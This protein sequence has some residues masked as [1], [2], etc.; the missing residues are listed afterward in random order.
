MNLPLRKLLTGIV[1]DATANPLANDA[2]NWTGCSPGKGNLIGTYRDISACALSDYL[3][4]PATV[5]D[6]R[7]LTE[8]DTRTI[9][10]SWWDKM[11]M[12]EVPDQDVANIV[13]HLRMH[14]GNVHI[15]QIALRQ[16]GENVDIDGQFGPQ[17]LEAL[18]RQ[19]RRNAG[20]TYTAIR[21]LLKANYQ[22]SDPSVRAGFMRFL[23][24]DFPEKPGS[25]KRYWLKAAI[26]IIVIALLWYGY[27]HFKN[28]KLRWK[29]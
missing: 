4:R 7:N 14:F 22:R 1:N 11:R 15:A 9:I 16:L 21:N 6:L 23:T 20:K 2:G 17:T 27:K 5:Q 28:Y 26:I 13:F 8:A 25:A 18:K 29:A 10:R 24:D 19:T 12:S 3:K